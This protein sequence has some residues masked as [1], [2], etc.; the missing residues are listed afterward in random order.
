MISIR[1]RDN[2]LPVLQYLYDN[3]RKEVG[4]NLFIDIYCPYLEDAVI[5]RIN[6]F[7]INGTL[8]KKTVSKT[9][10]IYELQSSN[11]PCN[12]LTSAI[13]LMLKEFDL[14]LD[15][16]KWTASPPA[17]PNMN[18]AVNINCELTVE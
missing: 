3:I 13:L 9:I 15:E 16:G 14:Y 8:I 5:I 4:K 7:D 6:E 11:H 12:A 2:Y 17:G 10:S 1:L 18:G